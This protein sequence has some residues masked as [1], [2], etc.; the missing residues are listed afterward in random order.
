M[1]STINYSVTDTRLFFGCGLIADKLQSL[2]DQDKRE[3]LAKYGFNDLE[4]T[5]ILIEA[6]KTIKAIADNDKPVKRK[7]TTIGNKTKSSGQME[8]Q[9]ANPITPVETGIAERIDAVVTPIAIPEAETLPA[10]TATKKK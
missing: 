4:I 2:A 6:Q 8:L 10:T 3:L 1:A 9:Q 5:I 7:R